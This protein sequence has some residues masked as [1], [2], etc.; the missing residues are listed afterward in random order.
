LDR[1]KRKHRTG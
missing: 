1:L